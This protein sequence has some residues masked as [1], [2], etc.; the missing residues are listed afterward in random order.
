MQL[1]ELSSRSL[2]DKDGD[3]NFFLNWSLRITLLKGQ[4]HE[5]DHDGFYMYMMHRS[6]PGKEPEQVFEF[7]LGSF[8]SFRLMLNTS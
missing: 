4:S 6:R 3:F 1:A 5:I 7:F 2:T 8:D